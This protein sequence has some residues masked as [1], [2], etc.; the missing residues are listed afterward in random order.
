MIR[1][2]GTRTR[3]RCLWPGPRQLAESAQMRLGGQS[4]VLVGLPPQWMVY[5]VARVEGYRS[6]SE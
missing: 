3:Q 6:K 4:Q 5:S 1:E 2:I